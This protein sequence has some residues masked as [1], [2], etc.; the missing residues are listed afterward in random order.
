M[1]YD[2]YWGVKISRPWQISIMNMMQLSEKHAAKVVRA[3]RECKVGC[4]L[5]GALLIPDIEGRLP[6]EGSSSDSDK[7]CKSW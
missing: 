2:T 7:S 6:I 4:R 1:A 3:T 5:E